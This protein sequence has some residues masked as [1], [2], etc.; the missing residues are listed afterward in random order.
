MYSKL[1]CG[2]GV[3]RGASTSIAVYN[4]TTALRPAPS[5]IGNNKRVNCGD[6][7]PT[8]R[9][10]RRTRSE[11]TTDR[12]IIVAAESLNL[13][14]APLNEQYLCVCVSMRARVPVCASVRV[15]VCV[16]AARA[17]M[18]ACV[19]TRCALPN[20]PSRSC[21][22]RMRWASAA[23]C[24]KSAAGAPVRTQLTTRRAALKI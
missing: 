5:A 15:R 20:P 19:L 17:C 1:R 11:T 18:H 16:R 7:L 13:Y 10:S 24:S 14:G 4:V 3:I 2:L 22:D 8:N 6:H 9:V 23:I 21:D 12:Q